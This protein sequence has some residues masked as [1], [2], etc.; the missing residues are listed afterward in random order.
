[1][2]LSELSV[3]PHPVNVAAPPAWKGETVTRSPLTVIV[4]GDG[5]G[6]QLPEQT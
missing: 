4:C 5:H 1:M 2:L 6:L 3:V